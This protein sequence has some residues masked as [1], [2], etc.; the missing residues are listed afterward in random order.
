MINGRMNANRLENLD[1]PDSLWDFEPVD[2]RK[3][4]RLSAKV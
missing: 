1:I 2:L 3:E 4:I